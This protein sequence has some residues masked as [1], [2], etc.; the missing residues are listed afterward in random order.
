MYSPVVRKFPHLSFEKVTQDVQIYVATF[1]FS[2]LPWMSLNSASNL[3][4]N[5]KIG[6]S[7][8]LSTPIQTKTVN[9]SFT[10]LQLSLI[11]IMMFT[12]ITKLL[13]EPAKPEKYNW[14]PSLTGEIAARKD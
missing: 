2:T 10:P 12:F 7:L 8:P 11:I 1:L 13:S 4:F 5:N 9:S 14:L 3:P 6:S